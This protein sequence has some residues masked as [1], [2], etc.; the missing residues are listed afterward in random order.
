MYQKNPVIS[1]NFF[2]S[3]H[4]Q[5]PEDTLKA[6]FRSKT[7]GGLPG[8]ILSIYLQNGM[9]LFG[10][11]AS[12]ELQEGNVEK[13]RELAQH[14]EEK[15]LKDLVL[16]SDLEVQERASVMHQFLKYSVKHL[17]KSDDI[18]GKNYGKLREIK[19]HTF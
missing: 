19:L 4:L 5:N 11:I 8:H 18:Q 12:K 15:V 16:S 3:E 17:D 9:K 1:H 2:F 7:F 13:I 10:F 14:L 6:L